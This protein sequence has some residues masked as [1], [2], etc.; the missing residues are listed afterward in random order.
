LPGAPASGSEWL[1]AQGNDVR[2][3]FDGPVHAGLLGA[4]DDEGLDSSFDGA[5]AGE[6]A[7]LAEVGVARRNSPDPVRLTHTAPRRP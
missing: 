6:H 4:L 5:R 2:G 3:A 1:A 7:E